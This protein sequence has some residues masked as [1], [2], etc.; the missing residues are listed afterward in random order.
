MALRYEDKKYVL[1]KPLNEID[2]SKA[3][4]K[5]IVDYGA[6]YKHATKVSCI[7][8]ATMTPKLQRFY[9]DY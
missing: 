8:V 1:N 6:Y 2:E 3:S 9:E 7:M 5:E 4:P